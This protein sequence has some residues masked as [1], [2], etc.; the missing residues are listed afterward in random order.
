MLRHADTDRLHRAYCVTANNPRPHRAYC[1]T[2]NNPGDNV[3]ADSPSIRYIIWQQERGQ[4]GTHHLQGYVEFY[5]PYRLGAAAAIIAIPAHLEP[6]RGTRDQAR[7]YCRKPDTRLPDTLPVER[8]S[9]ERGGRGART[10]LVDVV[11]LIDT[12]GSYASVAASFPLQFIRYHRGIHEYVSVSRPA[13]QRPAPLVFVLWGPT[14]VGKSRL[15]ADVYPD[16]YW[17][18]PSANGSHYALGYSGQQSVI[19]DDYYGSIPYPF[20]LRILD[21]YKLTVNVQG[22]NVAFRAHQF[23]FTSNHPPQH[24]YPHADFPDQSA[25]FRRLTNIYECHFENMPDW[26]Q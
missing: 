19:F 17:W 13:S 1:F 12:G 21:R 20:L 26:G 5:R 11:D 9:W 15:A 24:W 8:G 7:E 6:R 10:D 2:A 25:L 14:G 18:S 23:I 16:A 3:P 4:S 22:T